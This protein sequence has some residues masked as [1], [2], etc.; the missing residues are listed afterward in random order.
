VTAGGHSFI[1]LAAGNSAMVALKSNGQIWSWG[2]N[3]NGMLG[4]NT[5]VSKSSP[6]QI[7]TGFTFEAGVQYANRRVFSVTPGTTYNINGFLTNIGSQVM[8]SL[9][10]NNSYIVLEYYG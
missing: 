6:V 9:A 2:L 7:V 3:T 5:V 1:S 8:L 4:D 10:Q